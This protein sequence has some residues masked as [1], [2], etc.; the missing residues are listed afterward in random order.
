MNIN[1][2]F[3][4]EE[5]TCILHNLFGKSKGYLYRLNLAVVIWNNIMRTCFTCVLYK[6]NTVVKLHLVNC[7]LKTT[8]RRS[9][10]TQSQTLCLARGFDWQFILPFV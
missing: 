4:F 6:T 8:L 10:S 7:Y 9:L 2:R 1:A 3:K 5:I